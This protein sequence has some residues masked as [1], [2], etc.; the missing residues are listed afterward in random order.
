M[1]QMVGL[2]CCMST[3]EPNGCQL[4]DT[5]EV[6]VDCDRLQQDDEENNH[7]TMTTTESAGGG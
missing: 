3:T 6:F 2:P 7:V 5:Q 1:R 4:V